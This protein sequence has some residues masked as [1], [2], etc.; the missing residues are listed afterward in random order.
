ME[1]RV[2]DFIVNGV[3]DFQKLKM[4]VSR[5]EAIQIRRIPI[6]IS[7]CSDKLTWA[8]SRNGEYTVKSGYIEMKRSFDARMSTAKAGLSLQV[9]SSLWPSIWKIKALPKVKHF[10]WRLCTNSLPLKEN[11][12][13]R[14]CNLSSLC[15]ICELEPETPEHLLFFCSWARAVWLSSSL[16]CRF[17]RSRLKRV[18]LWLAEVFG[19][20]VGGDESVFALVA[21][22]CWFIWKGRYFFVFEKKTSDPVLTKD[23]AEKACDE[24]LS[25]RVKPKSCSAPPLA[26]DSA[27][28]VWAPPVSGFFKANVDGAFNPKDLRAGL[29]VIFR[30]FEGVVLDGCSIPVF[31]SSC[32]MVEAL[33]VR[34]AVR[35]ARD[36]ELDNVVI[37]SDC[38]DLVN[39]IGSDVNRQC[40]LVADWLA[41]AAVRRMCPLGW[42]FSPPSSLA[43]LLALDACGIRSGI[44]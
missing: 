43:S 15:P 44:G 26:R 7:R 41:K 30:D 21:S 12:F 36:L 20:V 39:S 31:A 25:V 33:A 29:G 13:K 10:L 2:E 14:R 27:T 18:D 24:F 16:S 42:V 34:Q 38:A 3:W 28:S 17:D 1:M 32:L 23:L 19:G 22:I 35:M 5:E 40:N 6:S 9:P 11:L 4:W 37:E 8:F